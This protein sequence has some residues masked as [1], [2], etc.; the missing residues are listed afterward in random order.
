MGQAPHPEQRVGR[1]Q[2]LLLQDEGRLLP[3][4]GR[5]SGRRRA[6]ERLGEL[7]RRLPVGP[8]ASHPPGTGPQLFRLLLRDSESAGQ[9]LPTCQA[10]FDEA[11]AQLDT[12]PEDSYKD[13]TLIMQLLRD[14]LTLWTS[15][16]QGEDGEDAE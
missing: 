2:G 14:N 10:A 16:L 1:V 12:L 8:D 13:S 11:I 15:D 7:A 9:G 3:L 5:V 6:Q 4:H